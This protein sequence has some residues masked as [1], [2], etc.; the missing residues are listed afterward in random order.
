MSDYEIY[1][2]P[3]KY[4]Q[5]ISD[6]GKPLAESY[7]QYDLMKEVKYNSMIFYLTKGLNYNDVSYVIV[8]SD[9]Y[10]FG[11]MN[12]GVKS[13]KIEIEKAYKGIK[14]VNFYSLD[15]QIA[16]RDGKYLI[17]YYFDSN[18]NVDKIYIG[19]GL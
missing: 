8:L 11:N 12:V 3:Y 6:F 7:T 10:R 13:S 9:K 17:I 2:D 18:S 19:I 5:M 4:S 15:D 14:E 16:Y 1:G